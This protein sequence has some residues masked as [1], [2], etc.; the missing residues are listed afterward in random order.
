MERAPNLAAFGA[1]I[2]DPA[3]AAMLSALIDGSALPAGELAYAAN[4]TAQTASA[5]LAKLVDGGLL[6]VEREGRHRYYRIADAEVAAIIESLAAF[7]PDQPVRRR[8]LSPE[9]RDLREA[10]RCYDHLAGRLGVTVAHRLEECRFLA[11]V[12]DKRYELT[13]AGRAWFDALGIDT[14]GL[15][16]TRL[17]LARQCL[18]WT[19]RRH[20]LAGPLGAAL[21]TRFQ[22]LG[23][24]RRSSRSRVIRLTPAGQTKLAG[25]LGLPASALIA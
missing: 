21:L 8:A 11:P 22:E 3:R 1:L 14:S 23:W 20:H 6:R 18:D 15:R 4:V 10:R 9:A 25:R 5:H 12:A 24:V 17:G 13:R 16:P 19:E 7:G 2:G